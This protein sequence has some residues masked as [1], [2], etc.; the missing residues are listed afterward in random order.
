MNI[1]SEWYVEAAN[2]TCGNFP[3]DTDEMEVAGLTKLPCGVIDASIPRVGEAAVQLECEVHKQ[4]YQIL[5]LHLFLFDLCVV[6]LLC[7]AVVPLLNAATAASFDTIETASATNVVIVMQV[8]D[9]QPVY[10]EDNVHTCTIVIGRVVCYHLHSAVLTDE[11]RGSDAP[12]VDW[13]KLRAVG[14]MGGNTF[15]F[16][17]NGYDLP[18]PQIQ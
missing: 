17:A 13:R 15:T 4:R 14:R 1:M 10:N 8:H 9:L 11:S 3:P 12:V 2:H 16:A 18:R 6:A 5:L 7:I